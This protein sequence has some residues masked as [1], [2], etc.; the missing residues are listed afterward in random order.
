MWQ[1]YNGGYRNAAS[2]R[3][4]DDPGGSATDGTQLQLWDCN[5]GANQQWVLG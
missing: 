2:G 4:L 3:C 1:V 5:S